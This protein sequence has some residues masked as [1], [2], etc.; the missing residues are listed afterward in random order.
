MNFHTSCNL[1]NSG[2]KRLIEPYFEECIGEV[3]CRIKVTDNMLTEECLNAY[4]GSL[5]LTAVCQSTYIPHYRYI[6]IYI[7]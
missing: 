2:T 7:Y 6:Y 4:D 3:E 5:Y 1:E